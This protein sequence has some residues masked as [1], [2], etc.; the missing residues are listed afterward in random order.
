M[1]KEI[2]TVDEQKKIVQITTVDERF[3]AIPGKNE[4]SGLPEYR[5]L[6]SVTYITGFYPKGRFFE[7]WLRKMGNESEI[8]KQLAG[9]K[10][11]KVHQAI[12]LLLE[13][14]TINMQIAL[15]NTTTGEQE[16]INADEYEA[17]VSFVSWFKAVKPVVKAHD[18]VIMNDELGYAGTLDLLC[19]IGGKLY[20][21]DFK[22]S[23][24]IW[25]SH[26]L[27]LS[28]YKHTPL[29]EKANLAILQLG[30]ARNGNRYKFTE[31]EDKFSLFKNVKA[32][33]DNEE[34]EKKPKQIEL[35]LEIALV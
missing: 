7:E 32:I 12:S 5:F 28:A 10:G 29:C 17:V 33:F 11:S 16:E 4:K 21:V 18:I 25:P 15:T 31:I 19:E 8:I 13:G 1:K 20:I 2:R 27:Q 34:G 22:T 35:P 6:P 23:A 3:Y 9:E 14:H 24:N 30:Y 26:E